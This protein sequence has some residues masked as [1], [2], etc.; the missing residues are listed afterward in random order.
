MNLLRECERFAAHFL[1][2]VSVTCLALYDSTLVL[3]PPDSALRR[4][5]EA[6]IQCSPLQMVRSGAAQTFERLLAEFRISDGSSDART[7]VFSPDC[8]KFVSVDEE[9]RV[10]LWDAMSHLLLLEFAGHAREQDGGMVEVKFSPDGLYVACLQGPVVHM[11]RVATGILERTIPVGFVKSFDFTLDGDHIISPSIQSGAAFNVWNITPYSTVLDYPRI[12]GACKHSVE[13][14]ATSPDGRWIA[15]YS[16]EGDVL[17]WDMRFEFSRPRVL[18]LDGTPAVVMSNPLLQF[19]RDSRHILLWDQ[20]RASHVAAWMIT[21]SRAAPRVLDLGNNDLMLTAIFPC[22]DSRIIV[23]RYPGLDAD[24]ADAVSVSSLHVETGEQ[25][26]MC[27]FKYAQASVQPMACSTDGTRILSADRYRLIQIW[28][29]TPHAQYEPAADSTPTRIEY[30]RAVF[31]SSGAHM[32]SW[33]K[34]QPGSWDTWWTGSASTATLRIH[35]TATWRSRE[36]LAENLLLPD[37]RSPSA[38]LRHLLVERA[39]NSWW[40]LDHMPCSSTFPLLAPPASDGSVAPS[41]SPCLGGAL[42]HTFQGYSGYSRTRK[43]VITLDGKR[44]ITPRNTGVEHTELCDDGAIFVWELDTLALVRAFRG[45]RSNVTYISVSFNGT[46]L[47]SV[48]EYTTVQVWDLETGNLAWTV[49]PRAG[50]PRSES[51]LS[52]DVDAVVFSSTGDRIAC[53]HNDAAITLLDAATG[54]QI[55]VTSPGDLNLVERSGY[56][57]ESVAFTPRSDIIISTEGSYACFW[58]AANGRLLRHIHRDTFPDVLR[59]TPDGAGYIIS[60]SSGEADL[61]VRLWTS[62]GELLDGVP[63]DVAQWMG[64]G[65][66]TERPAYLES[67]GWVYEMSPAGNRRMFWLP[68]ELRPLV[69]YSPRKYLVFG[70]GQILDISHF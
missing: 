68:P 7:M 62:L 40:F 57:F 29:T 4:A 6:E 5:Y 13:M 49:E 27:H 32:L 53:R 22:A 66:S 20:D 45:P 2:A 65:P 24:A 12:Q 8:S 51:H 55:W 64:P 48:T 67:R 50:E 52:R 63:A 38:I 60:N 15:S 17:L 19:T 1:P 43:A 10:K 39:Y 54:R 16:S 26:P 9:N 35:D 3:T 34:D 25:T 11:W 31:S 28:D 18:N 59:I 42:P 47:V 33:S 44:M 23:C 46:V 21:G 58:D 36:V 70:N 37:G 41:P 30:D 61:T 69:G 14:I 56:T